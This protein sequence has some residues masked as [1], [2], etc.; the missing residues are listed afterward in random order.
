MSTIAQT[1]I[2]QL[3][4]NRFTS[5]TGAKNFGTSGRD[6]SFK[7]GRGA[8]NGINYIRIELN[9]NDTYNVQFMKCR[10]LD[11]KVVKIVGNVYGDKLAETFRN[12]TGFATSL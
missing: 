1:I 3:G 6:L 9:L 4:G 11:C 12:C 8:T 7:I 5:M 2:Q 10:G